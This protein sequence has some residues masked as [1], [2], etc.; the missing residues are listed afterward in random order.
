MKK[1]YLIS[2]T[3]LALIL[4][5][6]VFFVSVYAAVSQTISVTNQI[7]FAGNPNAKH[8]TIS[9][10]VAGTIN[11]SDD[12]LEMNWEYD[13]ENQIGLNGG[14][15][16][17]GDLQFDSSSRNLDIIGITYTFKITNQS[18]KKIK[19]EFVGP[20]E[21]PSGLNKTYYANK[22]G[23]NAESKSSI[24]ILGYEVAYLQ[25]KLTI[26]DLDYNCKQVPVNFSINIDV[27]E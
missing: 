4:S 13:Y 21:L 7:S 3:V 25:L 9:G 23:A 18:D 5:L 17:L 16:E 11:D 6:S 12:K 8:F 10:K 22:D 19:A 15:W 2:A 20:E 1:R 26:S 14:S 27:A 24:N